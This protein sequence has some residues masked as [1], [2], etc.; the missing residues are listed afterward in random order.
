MS[1]AAIVNGD[2]L[3]VAIAAPNDSVNFLDNSFLLFAAEKL[4]LDDNIYRL[5]SDVPIS[6]LLLALAPNHPGWIASIRRA[7]GWMRCGTRG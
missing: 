3:E 4:A 1:H 7:W 2:P 5:S 6:N